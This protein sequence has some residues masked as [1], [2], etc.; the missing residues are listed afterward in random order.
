MLD[1]GNEKVWKPTMGIKR[2][3]RVER[4]RLI[5][6]WKHN[7][8]CQDKKHRLHRQ[9]T[10]KM[11]DRL[12]STTFIHIFFFCFGIIERP[13][14][15]S[16]RLF[17]QWHT[18]TH[19]NSLSSSCRQ[20]QRVCLCGLMCYLSVRLPFNEYEEQVQHRNRVVDVWVISLQP[21]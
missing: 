19:P 8:V 15:A 13:I 4:L 20:R 21:K 16:R 17:I 10:I 5:K 9:I 2:G 7:P 12:S 14:K 1:G 11:N 18:H 6:S 3:T